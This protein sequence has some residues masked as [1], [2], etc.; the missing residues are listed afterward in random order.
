MAEIMSKA[1]Q[2]PNEVPLFGPEPSELLAGRTAYDDVDDYSGYK[3]SPPIDRSGTVMTGL[4]T[5]QREV[6]VTLVSSSDLTRSA[7]LDSGLKRITVIV[8]RGG[9]I[10][11][12]LTAVRTAAAPN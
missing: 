5:W 3:E 7:V 6:A 4:A 2:D 9:Q 1:Y 11:A 8:R 10:M 12:Q